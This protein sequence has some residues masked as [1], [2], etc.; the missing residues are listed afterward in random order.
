MNATLETIDVTRPAEAAE[1]L[2]RLNDRLA[3]SKTIPREIRE[4]VRAI[5]EAVEQTDIAH[6]D[7]IDPRHTVFVL[8]AAISAQ[9]ALESRSRD[10]LRLALDSL[11]QAFA[12]IAELEPVS[13]SRSG[14]ELVQW[15]A[16]RTEVAQARLAE[17]IG[18]SP[19]QFQRWLSPHE[20]AQPEGGDLRKVRALARIV[21]Q[22]RF[23]LTPAGVVEWFGWKL[24]DLGGKSPAQLLD[25]PEQ[26]P[27]LVRVAGGMRA[28]Y[29]S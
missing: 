11:G 14:K 15:L 1:E 19:R 17:L 12:A 26:L 20:V 10:G 21:N 2:M 28:T 18:V 22:L 24:P 29:A 25:D 4:Q 3:E 13:D 9:L 7:A 8:R 23:A 6:W 5:S 16:A 27:K